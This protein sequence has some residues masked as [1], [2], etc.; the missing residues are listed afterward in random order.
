MTPDRWRQI[1]EIFNAALDLSPD[2][3][4]SF[5][6]S[7]CGD[8][9]LKAEVE[10]L[11]SDFDSAESFIESPVWTDSR[12]LESAM[13]SKFEDS[14]ENKSQFADRRQFMIGRR[15][16]VYELKEEIGRGGMGAVY[17]AERADGEFRQ[18]V[19][20]KLIKRGM[21]T[22][23]V[24]SRFRRERQI[25]A[26]LNHSNIVL[27]LDGGTTEDGLPYFVMDY[28]EGEPIHK[29]C[30]R[31]NLSLRERLE[32]FRQVCEAIDYAHRKKI[33]HRD[34]K[35]SN[36]LINKH[37][38][39]KLLDFGIAKLLDPEENF[40]SLAQT[41]T[42]MRLMTPEYASPEQA[43]GLPITPASD[44]YSL[45]VLLYLIVT[46]KRPYKFTTRAPQ[47]VARIICEEQPAKP[48]E[49]AKDG[50]ENAKGDFPGIQRSKIKDQIN[51]ALDKIIL[52][53]LRKEPAERYQTA[54]ELSED[55][56]RFLEKRPVKAE[57]FPAY[58]ARENY[59]EAK[60]RKSSGERS[61]AVLPFKLL[62]TADTG[63]TG[64]EFLSLGLA[65]SLITRLSN[66][67]RLTVRPTSS[68]LPFTGSSVNPFSAGRELGVNYVL[69]GNIRRDGNRLRV[70][71]QLLNTADNSTQWAQKF[72]EDSA[73]VIEL[74][75]SISEKV[76]CCLL[77]HLTG[78]ERQ[79]LGKR[80]TSK[81]EAYEVYL[82]GRYFWNKFTAES[83]PKA[84]QSFQKAIEL[85]PEYALA[86]VGLADYYTWANIYGILPA[87]ESRP[88]AEHAARRALEL[89]DSLGEAY[90]ALG[91]IHSNRWNWTESERLYKQALELNP[92]YP[93]VHEWYSAL[94]VGTGRPEE[95]IR[96]ILIAERL[97]PLSLRT[98]T[99][100]A[101]T[102]YQTRFFDKALEKAGQ[103]IEL[104][105]NYPQGYLQ[106]G[107][108]LTELGEF[109]KAAEEIQKCIEMMPES[110]LPKYP[111]CFALA[112]A[113]RFNEAKAVV[114][115]MLQAAE[116]NYVKPYFLAMAFAAIG[117]SETA[118]KYF[119][120]AFEERDAWLLWF[121]TEPKLDFLRDNPRFQAL[122]R[123]TGNPAF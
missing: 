38:M 73:D 44:I 46:G 120:K 108:V 68:V 56:L 28:V 52:K 83:L 78:E 48:S 10:K 69:D 12:L 92:N 106:S 99:L 121:G 117:E 7:K 51:D 57:F 20:V 15:I 96:E 85:D 67:R 58:K 30:T 11:L 16:G 70:S 118:F 111:L 81:P 89:D 103:I 18:K 49:A 19:A 107:N 2:E 75:D 53:A 33:V 35:P 115:E 109:N 54:A 40:D 1:E 22:D 31:N 95:G 87:S 82:R 66:V 98:M 29:Y 93:H 102:Y 86:Y 55:I 113:D 5:I 41:D 8:T 37:G 101:W 112:R 17:L 62:G 36:I 84:H 50:S 25:L 47:E 59:S 32:L 64:D 14:P 27:L 116:N 61:I 9:E 24:L 21:D 77:T 100:V 97:D 80:G 123:R 79:K 105:K 122:L 71:V 94:L 23:F 104:D 39:P 60:I 76:V 42:Q 114:E 91:L 63:D 4:P 110:P 6:N 26:N 3:R 119:E 43:S 45:G 90:A 34:L 88:L 65:D 13:K 72:D 74:E